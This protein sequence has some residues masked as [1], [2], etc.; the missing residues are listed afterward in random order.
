[1]V[2]MGGAMLE[3]AIPTGST[4]SAQAYDPRYLV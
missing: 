1:M 2:L 3:S 4:A